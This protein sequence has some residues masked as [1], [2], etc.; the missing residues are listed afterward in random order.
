MRRMRVTCPDGFNVSVQASQYN[1]CHPRN[2]VGPYSEVE[3]GYPSEW[4]EEWQPHREGETGDVA[5]YLP[6]DLVVRVLLQHGWIVSGELPPM[7]LPAA[8]HLMIA[9]VMSRRE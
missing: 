6:V 1:Y 4:P 9:E 8:Y 7:V 3:V 5:G 2:D